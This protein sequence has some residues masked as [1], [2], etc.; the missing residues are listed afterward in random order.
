MSSTTISQESV[1]AK[2]TAPT[3]QKDLSRVT[4]A[5]DWLQDA[6]IEFLNPTPP[7]LSP[8]SLPLVA[9]SEDDTNAF[10]VFPT[11]AGLPWHTGF[12][13]ARQNRHWKAGLKSSTAALEAFAR[14]ADMSQLVRAA[15]GKSLAD[16]AARHLRVAE[17]DRFT[18]FPTYLWP[19]ADEE[20]T[21]LLAVAMVLAVVFDDLWEA[22]EEAKLDTI[23]D[24]F[25]RRLKGRAAGEE[26]SKTELQALIDSVVD[27]FKDQD[28]IAGDGGQEVIA[29]VVDF[30]KHVP[31]QSEFKSLDDYFTYRYVDVAAPF[32]I[33]GTK[34][35]ISSD[36]RIE[37][38]KLATIVRLAGDHISLVNDL[39]SFE[40]EFR[41]FEAGEL[42]NLVNAVSIVR[43]LFGLQSWSS[44]KAFTYAM[45]C[46]LETRIKKEVERLET[47]GALDAEQW[48]FLKALL[49]MLAGNVFYST[50][51]SRYGGEGAKLPP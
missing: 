26:S 4:H 6:S 12:L 51:A 18:K 33:A 23:R 14:S 38:P 41:E 13:G 25:V 17:E 45:Q 27:G 44:A 35:S 7:A 20:R 42:R 15:D 49:T 43:K 28:R 50:I 10:D 2:I 47:I 32:L 39:A 24:D 48:R 8:S 19:E 3:N 30:S 22:H 34:F 5:Y 29:R 9:Q 46:E 16:V 1:N 36:V 11:A 31:P 37:D 21:K 40:K